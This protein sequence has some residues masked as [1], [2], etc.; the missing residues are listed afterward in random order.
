MITPVSSA[1]TPIP[2]VIA[3]MGVTHDGQIGRALELVEKAAWA[4]ANAVKT[5]FWSDTDALR[6]RMHTEDSPLNLEAVR[7]REEWLPM[8][9]QMA[10]NVRVE[11]LCTVDLFE[12]IPKVAPY[13]DRFKI[14]SWGATDSAFIRAH[15][16]HV[17][18]IVLSL[19]TLDVKE[20]WQARLSIIRPIDWL[21][22]CVS[23]YPAPMNELNLKVIQS[24]HLDGFSDHTGKTITGALAVAAGAQVLEVHCRHDDT[25]ADNPDFAHSLT[26]ADLK[27]YI[28]L[29]RTAARAL[30]D[31]VKRCTLSERPNLR[32]RY[33]PPPP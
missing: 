7:T 33:I 9:A 10:K 8:L 32:P 2:F 15:Q 12:D 16:R 5:Q 13:V 30:G 17:K 1:I 25:P 18:P 28:G 31:G 20:L 24:E 23:A 19:G 22:H 26:P 14:A 29:A 27:V 3:E 6:R 21:L 11:F 4:G